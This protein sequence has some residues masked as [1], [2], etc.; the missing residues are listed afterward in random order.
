VFLFLANREYRELKDRMR[1]LAEGAIKIHGTYAS[2]E[3]R[4]SEL[5]HRMD[6]LDQ[7]KVSDEDA[8]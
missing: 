2:L 3:K 6:T 4:M 8:D 1:I 7:K 5:Q